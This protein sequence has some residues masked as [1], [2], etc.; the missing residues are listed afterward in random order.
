MIKNSKNF[1]PDQV[2]PNVVGYSL[3]KTEKYLEYHKLQS[4]GHLSTQSGPLE[5]YSE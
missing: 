3:R 2:L 1:D 4:G 5:R